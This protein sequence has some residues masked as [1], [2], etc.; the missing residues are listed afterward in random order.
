MK[1]KFIVIFTLL[2]MV[3]LS[4]TVHSAIYHIDPGAHLSGN[5][6]AIAP[7][8]SWND[9]PSMGLGDDVY[10]KCDTI[11]KPDKAITVNW[12]GSST[13]R[14]IIGAYYIDGSKPVYSVLGKKPIISGNNF[15]I[16]SGNIPVYSGLI[17]LRNANYVTIQDIHI[18]ESRGHGIEISGANGTLSTYPVIQRCRILNSYM[19]AITINQCPENNAYIAENYIYNSCLA[20]NLK[21]K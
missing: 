1:R 16:P 14:V 15:T 5:G 12:S 10:F 13:N 8:K 3:F 9:L 7:F 6:S 17:R 11:T 21:L 19:S 20:G 2:G 4:K 18:E